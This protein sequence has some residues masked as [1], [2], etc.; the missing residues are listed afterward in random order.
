MI[1]TC[2]FIS[3]FD[4]S[5]AEIVLDRYIDGNTE[6][7][8]YF[9]ILYNNEKVINQYIST[10]G[11][12][13]V[14]PIKLK[15]NK[16]KLRFLPWI[17]S[18][19][20]LN[21]ID[22]IIKTIK[23]KVLYMNNTHEMMLCG[24]VAKKNNIKSIAHIHDMRKSIKSPIKRFLMD[25]SLKIYDEVITVSEATK[26]EWKSE[27]IKV[28]YNGIDS[29]YFSSDVNYRNGIQTFGFIGKIS[30]RK[31]FNLLYD[32]WNKK[33]DLKT[34]ELFICYSEAEKSLINKLDELKKMKNVTVFNKLNYE[35]TKK[36]YDDVD[37][38]IVPS[39]ADPLPT[40]IIEAMA[41]GC[42]VIGSNVDGIPELLGS[43]DLL[44]DVGDLD[45][46]SNKVV[47]IMNFDMDEIIN[48][49]LKLKKRCI[50]KFN[51]NRKKDLIN[52]IIKKLCI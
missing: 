50:D 19:K 28:I 42:L 34:K 22:D 20:I 36:F 29:D 4:Y 45:S 31:G 1:K 39:L 17:D 33:Q 48:T 9:I 7:D 2:F 37:V 13:C 49:S 46:L 43:D 6:I 38:L 14:F 26:R 8:P 47:E 15:H 27:N 24:I 3:G 41:R 32:L 16:N 40:V 25:R 12:E 52:N 10:Y 21:K 44:F 18:I 5:G 23:P 35:E 51:N 11:E 30:E